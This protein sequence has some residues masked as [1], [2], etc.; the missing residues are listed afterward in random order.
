[1]NNSTAQQQRTWN[2]VPNTVVSTS[3]VSCV[4]YKICSVPNACGSEY[5]GTVESV[6]EEV[7]DRCGYP[8]QTRFKLHLPIRELL[9][10]VSVEPARTLHGFFVF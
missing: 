9:G 6:P 10:R 2:T 4:K 5:Q 8:T 1:M 7:C 3:T